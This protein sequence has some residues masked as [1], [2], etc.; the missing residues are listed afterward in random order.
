MVRDPSSRFAENASLTEKTTGPA[1]S[2]ETNESWNAYEVDT[3]SETEV[4]LEQY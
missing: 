3:Q 1:V 4:E 2:D